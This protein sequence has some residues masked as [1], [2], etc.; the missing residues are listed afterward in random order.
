MYRNFYERAEKN[1][2]NFKS[3]GISAE[4]QTWHFW[5]TSKNHYRLSKLAG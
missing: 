4:I 3:V 1:N 5:N 2:E